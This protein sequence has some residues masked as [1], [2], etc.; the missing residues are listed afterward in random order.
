MIA[1]LTRATPPVPLDRSGTESLFKRLDSDGNGRLTVADR[2]PT[3][4]SLS[5]QARARYAE[6]ANQI[7]LAP[8]AQQRD[9]ASARYQAMQ[10]LAA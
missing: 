2:A 3:V 1:S 10:G 7:D 9:A 5:P 4:L 8:Q 6:A